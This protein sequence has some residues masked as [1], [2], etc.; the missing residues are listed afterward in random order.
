MI[1][2]AKG[3]EKSGFLKSLGF[4]KED[5]LKAAMKDYQAYLKTKK[6]VEEITNEAKSKTERERDEAQS[7]QTAYERKDFHIK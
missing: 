1:E 5:D 7:K 4:E 2:E 6:S 3:K